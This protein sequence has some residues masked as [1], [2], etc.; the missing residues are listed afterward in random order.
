MFEVDIPYQFFA[1]IGLTFCSLADSC[2]DKSCKSEVAKS[3][4]MN[5]KHLADLFWRVKIARSDCF[6]VYHDFFVLRLRTCSI[7]AMMQPIEIIGHI[8]LS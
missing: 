3:V 1:R 6:D 5:T 2:V 8:M 4:T 7:V